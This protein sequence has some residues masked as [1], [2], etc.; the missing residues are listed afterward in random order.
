MLTVAA[1][2][3]LLSMLP[4]EPAERAWLAAQAD[5]ESSR[6]PAAVSPAGARGL[7]QFMAPTWADALERASLPARCQDLGPHDGLCAASAAA[8]YGRWLR[9][10]VGLRRDRRALSHLA[11]NAGPGWA[12]REIRSCERRPGCDGESWP[13]VR[14]ECQRSPAACAESGAYPGRIAGRVATWRGVFGS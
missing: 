6:R 5:V 11:Y 8:W 1:L 10:W 3:A 13:D 14:G 4:V 12:R 9:A 2:A 7:W